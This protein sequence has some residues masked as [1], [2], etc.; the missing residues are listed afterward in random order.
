MTIRTKMMINTLASVLVVAAL[1][2]SAYWGTGKL[3]NMQD[4]GAVLA[5]HAEDALE[6]AG[7]AAKLYQV[8]ADAE[9]NRDLNNS[10]SEWAKA[11]K[12]AYQSVVENMSTHAEGPEERRLVA[13]GK[14][15][16]DEVVSLYENKML[17]LLKATPEVTKEIREVDDAIDKQVKSMA[18]SMG[19]L[20]KYIDKK[21]KD[22]DQA[23]DEVRATMR[24]TCLL[25]GLLGLAVS[26]SLS[27]STTQSVLGPLRKQMEVL[28][29]MARGEGDLTRKLD[30][31]RPDEFGEL[32]SWFNQF[33]EKI[34]LI[35][36][37]VAT[38]SERVATAANQLQSTAGQIAAGAEEVSSQ[39]G[40]LATASEE[41]AT[42]GADITQSCQRAAE[43]A[44]HASDSA[45]SGGDVVRQ[46]IDGMAKIATK[47]QQAARTVEEL[48][49]K[50]SEIGTI[51]GT[52]EDIADQT[53][54]LALNAAIEAARAGDQGR[55]FAVVASEVRALAERT[56]RATR[57]TGDMIKAIQNGTKE[58]VAAMA[59]GVGEVEKGTAASQRSE[60]A[61]EEILSKI[62]EVALQI[63]QIA[64]A[65]EEQT[66]TTSEI[67]NN[68]LQITTVVDDTTRGAQET[69]TASADLS[70]LA[71]SLQGIVHQFKLAV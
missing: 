46:T 62:Q 53:N 11:K 17:P 65:V 55:G 15:G 47:V 10:A 19:L 68:I 9:I 32:A 43:S 6:A 34:A 4:K 35:I 64:T 30:A 44:S 8:I 66:A 33:L 57:E 12:E 1:I 18:E 20:R 70:Q 60:D 39:T 27:I 49:A 67:N 37:Q 45:Q 40:T 14:K 71:E 31:S 58:A 48:G 50:S 3:G 56:T 16:L 2:A 38:T 52:I 26:I 5:A 59:E 69:A 24:I 23:F 21:A 13:E 51:I 42:T 36:S 63:H 29:D 28:Q 7:M 25:V 54:L 22:A 61:L 41:M